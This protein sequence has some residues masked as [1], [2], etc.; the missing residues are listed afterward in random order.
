MFHCILLERRWNANEIMINSENKILFL[1]GNPIFVLPLRESLFFFS[2]NIFQSNNDAIF[3]KFFIFLTKGG[4]VSYSRMTMCCLQFTERSRAP[5][6]TSKPTP[7]KT[8]PC[9]R[10]RS[11]LFVYHS[12]FW[13]VKKLLYDIKII[14]FVE[15][16][17]A[18]RNCAKFAQPLFAHSRLVSHPPSQ[19]AL[20]RC[21]VAAR[22][23]S[24]LVILNFFNG[25][26]SSKCSS[27]KIFACRRWWLL[28]V[29]GAKK[30]SDE[31]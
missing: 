25:M 29:W 3:W 7:I 15:M 30:L 24:A 2:A 19:H 1:L 28:T 9:H 14:H 23:P 17:R 31:W 20:E 13:M 5:N 22:I 16:D 6:I 4:F 12:A 10:S 11:F 8:L 21:Q 18:M 27:G 26:Q